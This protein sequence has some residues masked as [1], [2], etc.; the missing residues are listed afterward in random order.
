MRTTILAVGDIEQ[1]AAQA[2][3]TT[4]NTV[5]VTMAPRYIPRGPPLAGCRRF[6]D[7]GSVSCK[8]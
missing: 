8:R 5:K 4:D 2:M 1:M 6:W 7:E 3:V